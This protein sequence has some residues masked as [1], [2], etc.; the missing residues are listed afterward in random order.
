MNF[1]ILKN[2]ILGFIISYYYDSRLNITFNHLS[3]YS[4]EIDNI[5]R[6]IIYPIL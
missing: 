6:I 3:T 1:L 2:N 5:N 4:K